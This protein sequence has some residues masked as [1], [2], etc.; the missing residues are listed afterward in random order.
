MVLAGIAVRITVARVT[1]SPCN[2]RSS[3]TILPWQIDDPRPQPKPRKIRLLI[4]T[5]LQSEL[6][7]IGNAGNCTAWRWKGDARCLGCSSS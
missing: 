4:Y 3:V 2:A 5:G 6:Y 1:F 7:W